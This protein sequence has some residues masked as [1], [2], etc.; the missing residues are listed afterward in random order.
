[1]TRPVD[2]ERQHKEKTMGRPIQQRKIGT[3]SAKIQV[4]S[5]YFTGAGSATTGG[6]ASPLYIDRQ[7]S[8]V[9]FKVAQVGSDTTEVLRLVPKSSP[10]EGEFSIMVTLDDT[11]DGAYNDSSIYYVAKLHNRTV[12]VCQNDD[13][14]TMIHLPYTLQPGENDQETEG[15]EIDGFVLANI[16]TQA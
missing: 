16:D 5:A 11:A 9:R 12:S 8:S 2:L 7:R 1:V 14:T 3:G 6:T 10:A 4:T 13:E 15:L